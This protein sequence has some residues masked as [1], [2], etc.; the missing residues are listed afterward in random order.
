MQYD[1]NPIKTRPSLRFGVKTANNEI[2]KGR[3]SQIVSICL[4]HLIRDAKPFK[5]LPPCVQLLQ[6]VIAAVKNLLAKNNLEQNAAKGKHIL[7]L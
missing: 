6:N 4:Q 2:R 1:S 5:K 7:L 3:N